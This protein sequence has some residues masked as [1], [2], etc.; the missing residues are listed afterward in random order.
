MRQAIPQGVER[1]GRLEQNSAYSQVLT[2]T[3]PLPNDGF[4]CPGF[5][6]RLKI[7]YN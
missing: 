3:N 7:R 4:L 5:E 6:F 1:D 2:P